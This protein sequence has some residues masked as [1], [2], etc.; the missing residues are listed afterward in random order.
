MSGS[1]EPKLSRPTFSVL[2][3][4]PID[5]SSQTHTPNPSSIIDTPRKLNFDQAPSYES[6]PPPPLSTPRLPSHQPFFDI[7]LSSDRGSTSSVRT[8]SRQLFFARQSG[9]SLSSGRDST[10]SAQTCRSPHPTSASRSTG[11][12]RYVYSSESVSG[13]VQQ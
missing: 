10:S 8:S 13:C 9:I 1:P 5:S 12:N 2:K 7:S 6:P 4:K 11:V 3:P